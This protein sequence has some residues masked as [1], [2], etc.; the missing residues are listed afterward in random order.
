MPKSH[1]LAFKCFEESH[2]G[3]RIAEALESVMIGNQIQNKVRWI[4]TDNASNIRKAM[5]VMFDD[6]ETFPP[7]M[8]NV[9]QIV[10]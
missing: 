7:L 5:S 10:S 8:S 1:L 9:L 2:T 4:V 3:Q 6:C